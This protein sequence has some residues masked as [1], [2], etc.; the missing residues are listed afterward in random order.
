MAVDMRN[1]GYRFWFRKSPGRKEILGAEEE[2]VKKAWILLG[3]VSTH[4]QH[5]KMARI[6]L[7]PRKERS[8]RYPFTYNIQKWP[9]F[10][11]DRE[12]S[13]LVTV[14]KSS[15]R[16]SRALKSLFRNDLLE[17]WNFVSISLWDF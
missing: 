2:A 15:K 7:R 10:D 3:A 6:G 11:C 13:G 8:E 17:H 4:L 5:P 9:E 12:K 1:L 14:H 16:L